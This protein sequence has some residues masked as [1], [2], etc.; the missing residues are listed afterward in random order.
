MPPGH[1]FTRILWVPLSSLFSLRHFSIKLCFAM[2]LINVVAI[3]ALPASKAVEHRKYSIY[4]STIFFD[5]ANPTRMVLP[6]LYIGDQYF[7]KDSVASKELP[8][9]SLRIGE[10]WV[11]TNI[12]GEVGRSWEDI[13]WAETHEKFAARFSDPA[14]PTTSED[15]WRGLDDVMEYLK[16]CSVVHG[17]SEEM[18]KWKEALSLATAPTAKVG[19]SENLVI[20]RQPAGKRLTGEV[21]V[22]IGDYK[23]VSPKRVKPLTAKDRLVSKGNPYY[24]GSVVKEVKI[25]E[26]REEAASTNR[27][28]GTAEDVEIWEKKESILT[29]PRPKGVP[30]NRNTAPRFLE[31]KFAGSS[32]N[33]LKDRSAISE[34]TLSTFDGIQARYLSGAIKVY[35]SKYSQLDSNEADSEVEMGPPSKRLK[36]SRGVEGK[37][38]PNTIGVLRLTLIEM[39]PRSPAPSTPLPQP[40]RTQ[41]HVGP[42]FLEQRSTL[43]AKQKGSSEISS[44]AFQE[45]YTSTRPVR[46]AL[47]LITVQLV[48]RQL[49]TKIIHFPVKPT[50][51]LPRSYLNDGKPY[52]LPWFADQLDFKVRLA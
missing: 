34:L 45:L 37:D 29:G 6:S 2:C 19:L 11:I 22:L 10:A 33:S 12:K 17:D 39:N 27:F 1:V 43:G 8:T 51:G 44:L 14:R 23:L 24:I 48:Q 13:I 32:M 7:G 16:E 47:T 28:R 5:D 20:Y 15:Y 49:R 3:V 41:K 21:S 18:R 35:K 30:G 4:L 38:Q 9:G 46:P 26:L 50:S 31:W 36:S 42:L 40:P 52:Q 25:N